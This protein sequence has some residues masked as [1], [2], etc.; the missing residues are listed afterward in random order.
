MVGPGAKR[1]GKIGLRHITIHLAPALYARWWVEAPGAR[2]YGEGMSEASHT[3]EQGEHPIDSK[4]LTLMDQ[5]LGTARELADRASE[6]YEARARLEEAQRAYAAAF[7]GAEKAGWDRKELTGHLA[8]EEPGRAP[9][10]RS[11]SRAK[12]GE[13]KSSPKGQSGEG[14][15]ASS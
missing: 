6:L 7:K 8:F 12:S 13:E 1:K 15:T 2:G 3:P 5:R 14:D 10:R 11:P 9:R 4:V